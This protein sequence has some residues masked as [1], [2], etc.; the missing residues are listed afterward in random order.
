MLDIF[1]R[2]SAPDTGERALNMFLRVNGSPVSTAALL[3]RGGLETQHDVGGPVRAAI[4]H[5]DQIF[6]VANGKLW[7]SVGGVVTGYG[8]FPDG[9]TRLASGATQIALVVGG[10]YYVWDDVAETV[11]LTTPGVLESVVDVAY[12]DG[13]FILAGS[14][15]GRD[16]CLQIT[17]LF[18]ATS[19]NPVDFAY[20]EGDSDG[21]RGLLSDHN[22]LWV[23]GTRTTEKYYN[24]GDTF[25]FTR[26]KGGDQPVGGLSSTTFAA[27]GDRVYW[28]DDQKIARVGGGGSSSVIAEPWVTEKLQGSTIDSAFMVRDRGIDHFV[29]RITDGP[30]L[31]YDL[32]TQLWHERS[33]GLDYGPWIATCRA[34]LK[35][36]EWVGTSTGKMCV[37][38]AT[39]YTDD[40][41]DMMAEAVSAP[42]VNK[43]KR[44]TIG[45]VKLL[46]RHL[47]ED[48]GRVPQ[49]VL[50]IAHDGKTFGEEKWRDMPAIGEYARQVTWK[51]LGQASWWQARIRI[52][53][54]VCRDL[55]GASYE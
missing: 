10:R 52:T 43:L 19:L 53:D 17:A 1:A 31:C 48:I 18:D 21:I 55:L 25:P 46:F 37:L 50:D 3:G 2:M 35:G 26:N 11:T 9:V 38:S 45:D 6:V 42:V 34:N 47:G 13:Y 27:G 33:T 29:I 8:S 30:A 12:M 14:Y 44:L 5:R 54:P 40:G 20:A 32:S 24:S 16:D 23:F 28:V 41:D 39:T 4:V 36:V 15:G 22:E 49:V 7:R 51:A